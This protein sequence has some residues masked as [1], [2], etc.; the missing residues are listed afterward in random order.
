MLIRLAP[1]ATTTKILTYSATGAAVRRPA[2]QLFN[3][4]Q[5]GTGSSW[6]DVA[7]ILT[8]QELA[9]MAHR[10]HSRRDRRFT[11]AVFGPAFSDSVGSVWL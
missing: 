11:K 5:V 6:R 2:L 3:L 8:V 10:V 9:G 4:N 1:A 7:R